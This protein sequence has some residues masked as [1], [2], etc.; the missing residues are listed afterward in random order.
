VSDGRPIFDRLGRWFT[1]IAVGVS[2]SG[3]LVTAAAKHRVPL[4]VLQTDERRLTKVYGS[5]L[6]LVRPDQHIAWRGRACEDSRVAEAI[7]AR[8]LGWEE[9]A[10]LYNKAWNQK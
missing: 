3:P 8:V 1:L 4:E 2:P 6:L 9:G 5:G 7:V 10:A